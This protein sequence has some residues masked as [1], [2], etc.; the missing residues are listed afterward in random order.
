MSK[1]LVTKMEEKSLSAGNPFLE[2][3]QSGKLVIGGI[4]ADK[5]LASTLPIGQYHGCIDGLEVNGYGAGPW[6]AEVR[7]RHGGTLLA[8]PR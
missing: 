4:P 8:K 6:N 1:K 2:I 3:G 7:D 5:R